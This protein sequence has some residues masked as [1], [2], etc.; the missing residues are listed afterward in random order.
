MGEPGAA[1]AHRDVLAE[2]LADE[3]GEDAKLLEGDRNLLQH[4]EPREERG[5][6]E[7][8]AH[9]IEHGGRGGGVRRPTD[10][11]ALPWF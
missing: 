1:E 9:L 6:G 8:H 5:E 2:H 10:L 7:E 4:E 3:H 11:C